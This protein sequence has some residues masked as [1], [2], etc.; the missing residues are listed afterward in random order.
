MYL[1]HFGC[2][3][4][5]FTLTSDLKFFCAL[6]SYKDIINMLT[7][8]FEHSEGIIK[9]IGEVGVG[10][11]M[12][13]YKLL[14]TLGDDYVVVYLTHGPRESSTV[15]G[16]IARKL[17][18]Y[19]PR[20]RDGDELITAIDNRL[21]D[22]ATLGKKVVIVVDEAHML[23]NQT[24]EDL[25]LLSNLEREGKKLL[26]LV[27]VGQPELDEKLRT[28]KLRQL[29]QKITFAY[30]L[31]ALSQKDTLSYL[32]FRLSTAGCS[33]GYETLFSPRAIKLLTKAGQGIP[34]LIN[35]LCH[36][37]MIIAYGHGNPRITTKYLKMALADTVTVRKKFN[38]GYII[39]I[40][41]AATA[42][43]TLLTIGSH[44]IAT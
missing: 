3:E 44:M 7:I 12:L 16:I 35:V 23:S 34:R 28:P 30:N 24:L 11:T 5:P 10:K 9:I 41:F 15:H 33:D 43:A 40:A 18:I 31:P 17:K 39:K 37:A 13:C 4:L 26:S 20:S 8:N 42:L 22:L 1:K 32:G 2:N 25:R 38:L 27:L 29:T 14:D 19:L 21:R 6:A 36:R